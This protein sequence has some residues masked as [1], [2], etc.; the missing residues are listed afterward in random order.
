MLFKNEII[1][2]F[3][4]VVGGKSCGYVGKSEHLPFLSIRFTC[5]Q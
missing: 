2:S 3:K 4:M 1:S 5:G